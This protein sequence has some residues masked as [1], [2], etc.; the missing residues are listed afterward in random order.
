MGDFS[1]HRNKQGIE[2]DLKHPEGK[3][4]FFNLVQRADAGKTFTNAVGTE[5][6][7]VSRQG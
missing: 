7:R 5:D 1:L 4:L 2:V 3:A 6:H